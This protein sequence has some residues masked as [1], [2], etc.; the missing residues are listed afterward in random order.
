M[1]VRLAHADVVT[2][3]L[4]QLAAKCTAPGG[5]ASVIKQ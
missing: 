5:A 1:G 3:T 2:S 4:Q